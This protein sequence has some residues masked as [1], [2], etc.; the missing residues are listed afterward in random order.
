MGRSYMIHPLQHF[1]STKFSNS[2]PHHSIEFHFAQST[3]ESRLSQQPTWP[4]GPLTV[5]GA[6]TL[7][8]DFWWAYSWLSNDVKLRAPRMQ[9]PPLLGMKDLLPQQLGELLAVGLS[10]QPPQGWRK[11]CCPGSPPFLEQPQPRLVKV[12]HLAPTFVQFQMA[13]SVPK[14]AVGLAV[15]LCWGAPSSTSLPT[16]A[17]VPSIPQTWSP[18]KDTQSCPTLDCSPPG[19]SIRGILQARIL[20]WV[21]FLSPGGLPDSGVEPG[22]P[23]C[24]QSLYCL[25]HQGLQSTPW[26]KLCML[27]I[28]ISVRFSEI[29]LMKI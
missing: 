19:S 6:G 18:V 22:L 28:P 4:L 3:V 29:L 17:S 15:S 8:P 24:R 21:V 14:P 26:L 13:I 10:W 9:R 11:H 1:Y 5:T 27:I 25:S 23:H 20:E 16:S 12:G 7:T 2:F